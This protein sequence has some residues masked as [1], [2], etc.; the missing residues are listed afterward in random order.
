MAGDYD[1]GIG[2]HIGVESGCLAARF[3]LSIKLTDNRRIPCDYI[4]A[5]TQD[6]ESLDLEHD[7]FV[8]PALFIAQLSGPKNVWPFLV[9]VCPSNPT[10][11]P[12]FHRPPDRQMFAAKVKY[13]FSV[14]IEVLWPN[15]K[16]PGHHRRQAQWQG[17]L[18][19]YT[20]MP[21][22]IPKLMKTY[23]WLLRVRVLI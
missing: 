15:P 18:N 16:M 8:W 11:S 3:T 17:R 1:D 6:R 23:W 2:W 9:F 20:N 7:P 4:L 12:T 5:V 10:H 14:F 13:K 21:Y 22:I 19:V